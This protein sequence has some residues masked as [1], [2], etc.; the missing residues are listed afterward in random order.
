MAYLNR[1][2]EK[3]SPRTEVTAPMAEE[4]SLHFDGRF[5]LM[6]VVTKN[7]I[8]RFSYRAV[9][10]QPDKDGKFDYSKERQAIR[11]VGPILEGEY[12]IKPQ[13]IQ[14]MTNQDAVRGVVEMPAR[15]LINRGGGN[16]PGGR[17]SWGM[18]RVWIYNSIDG[19]RI[20]WVEDPINGVK[21]ERDNFSIHGGATP[22]SRGCIDLVELD[23]DFFEDL[24]KYRNDLEKIRLS[25]MY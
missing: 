8:L 15:A 21:M 18:G 9:A 5:L 24:E 13:E 10:G 23:K 7:E 12:F 17:R 4:I 11:D 25:V 16:F 20:V 22:G 14:Y 19:S 3:V 1:P 2:T 6:R